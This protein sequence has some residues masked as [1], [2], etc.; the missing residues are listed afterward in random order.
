MSEKDN[1][2]DTNNSKEKI[3]FKSFTGSLY[4][5]AVVSLGLVPD[6]ITNE[7]RTNLPFA[8]ETIEILKML[9]EKTRGNLSEDENIFIDDCIYKLMLQ[10]VEVAKNE[11]KKV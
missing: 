8:Q 9:K 5:S 6:P 1:N 11:G 2:A 4:M 10:Y 7:K 3:N